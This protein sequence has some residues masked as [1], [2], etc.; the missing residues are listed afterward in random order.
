MAEIINVP[1]NGNGVVKLVAGNYALSVRNSSLNV[2]TSSEVRIL[3]D[4]SLGKVDIQ[5]PQ[6]KSFNGLFNAKIFIVDMNNK[7][8]DITIN[9]FKSEAFPVADLINGKEKATM[10][11]DNGVALLRIGYN[12]RW[13]ASGVVVG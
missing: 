5:L 4:T 9:G 8:A 2:E 3:C 10:Q 1:L 6:I 13:G 11:F 12:G 7:A